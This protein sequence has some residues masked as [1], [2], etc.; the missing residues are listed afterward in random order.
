EKISMK[1]MLRS[2]QD[3]IQKVELRNSQKPGNFTLDRLLE[4]KEIRLRKGEHVYHID[5][6]FE[7]KG[8]QYLALCLLQNDS[9]EVKC[10]DLRV[11]GILSVFNKFNKSVA[12]SSIQSPPIGIGIDEFEFWVPE[13]RPNGHNLGF[14]LNQPLKAFGKGNLLN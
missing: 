3:C 4:Q 6:D 10:S 13:R 5:F 7:S 8:S 11:T 2:A 1:L 12:T 14:E 9:V